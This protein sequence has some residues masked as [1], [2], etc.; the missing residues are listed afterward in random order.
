MTSGDMVDCWNLSVFQ[1]FPTLGVSSA[2]RPL[3]TPV[4]A[5]EV[6]AMPLGL[7]PEGKSG[8]LHTRLD[9]LVVRVS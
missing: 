5:D 8:P 1:L 2:S 6:W 4:C 9:G 7:R 3:P